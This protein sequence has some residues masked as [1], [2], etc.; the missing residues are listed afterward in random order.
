MQS[1]I[2]F[3]L[4]QASKWSKASSSFIMGDQKPSIL[5]DEW[6]S[7]DYVTGFTMRLLALVTINCMRKDLKSAYEKI[8]YLRLVVKQQT[9]TSPIWDGHKNGFAVDILHIP[10]RKAEFQ[11]FPNHHFDLNAQLED[12]VQDDD[13]EDDEWIPDLVEADDDDDVPA[14]QPA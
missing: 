3:W 11:Q 2:R 4:K 14:C 7:E 1:H 8:A 9:M 5:N 10:D 13:E 6:I 12:F